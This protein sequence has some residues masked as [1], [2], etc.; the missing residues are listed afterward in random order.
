M[1]NSDTHQFISYRARDVNQLGTGSAMDPS[2]M[3]NNTGTVDMAGY[4]NWLR[5]NGYVFTRDF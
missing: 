3:G 5:Q 1:T 2:T 4:L